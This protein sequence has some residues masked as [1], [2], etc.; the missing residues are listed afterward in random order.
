[1]RFQPPAPRVDILTP[2]RHPADKRF[3]WYRTYHDWLG[4]AK[5]RAVARQTKVP[6]AVVHCVV[7]GL[8]RA[9][10]TGKP[11]GHV[12]G[13][14]FFD[15]AAA[16]DTSPEQVA[17]VYKC[18]LE[19]GWIEDDYI[20]DWIER[21]PDQED[22][23]QAQRQRNRRAK[24]KARRAM[25]MGNAKPEQV[26][27]LQKLGEL[28]DDLSRVT[29]TLPVNGE[30]P[31]SQLT[32]LILW[33]RDL[34]DDAEK[35]STHNETTARRWLVGEGTMMDYGTASHIVGEHFGMKRLGADQMIRRWLQDL[36]GDAI[37]L[38]M[39][40][41]TANK[42]AIPGKGF[43]NVVEQGVAKLV[44]EKSAGPSLPL[45]PAAIKGGRR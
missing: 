18:L 43:Q 15:C 38:A 21:N 41:D 44:R 13:F 25:Q 9:A 22:P 17:T 27:L 26:A 33:P 34:Y 5:W 12:G 24:L 28:H 36:G 14:D 16:I 3:G 42:E 23:T 2:R 39:L 30:R 32:P 37:A 4:H 35:V 1:V 29:T 31:V 40:I 10:S 6:L 20:V 11:R 7:Q 45:G 8:F 19:R